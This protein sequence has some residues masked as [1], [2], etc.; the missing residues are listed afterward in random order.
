MKPHT[1]AF[2]YAGWK[3][4]ADNP[5]STRAAWD[6]CGLLAPFK[7]ELSSALL[8]KAQLAMVDEDPPY[9]PLFP[10]SG[11]PKGGAEPEFSSFEPAFEDAD[12]CAATAAR[13]EAAQAIEQ[14]AEAEAEQQRAAHA[15][16][17]ASRMRALFNMRAPQRT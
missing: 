3:A 1:P 14:Q 9:Y 15:A 11:V 7:P 13:F 8:A 6:V 10:A 2:L 16:S 12:Q 5:E 4:I 17:A